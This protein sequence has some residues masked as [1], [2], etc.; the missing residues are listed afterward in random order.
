MFSWKRRA[1]AIGED[2][3]V[4]VT[5]GSGTYDDGWDVFTVSV[6]GEEGWRKDLSNL[7]EARFGHGCASYM[8]GGQKV[9]FILNCIFYIF[10]ADLFRYILLLAVTT[11]KE[12]MFSIARNFSKTGYGPCFLK[13][14]Q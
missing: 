9:L 5:G 6:Y 13:V 3:H 8:S 1:C 12:T 11:R 10:N 7:T 4:I 2:D 14:Y